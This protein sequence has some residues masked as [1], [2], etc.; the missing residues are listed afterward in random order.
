MSHRVSPGGL[1]LTPSA[2]SHPLARI[3]S[4]RDRHPARL[5][6]CAP[7]SCCP[8]YRFDVPP[9][10]P[11]RYGP[12]TVTSNLL[13]S[14]LP[15]CV[16]TAPC[17]VQ[18]VVAGSTM[19]TGPSPYGVTWIPCR[20]GSDPAGPADEYPRSRPR[21]ACGRDVLPLLFFGVAQSLSVRLM[22]AVWATLLTLKFS[23]SW[24]MVISNHSP[25]S[26]S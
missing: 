22:T 16:Q 9:A 23:G 26:S 18:S 19:V 6:T 3:R 11:I 15:S 13:D 2:R 17:A 25:S 4:G 21:Y 20:S 14:I 10:C 8:E 12:G 5:S 1:R 24:P 7:L